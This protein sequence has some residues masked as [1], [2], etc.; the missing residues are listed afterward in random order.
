MVTR[1]TIRRSALV[2]GLIY[3][4]VLAFCASTGALPTGRNMP[5][6]QGWAMCPWILLGWECEPGVM[7][8]P[9]GL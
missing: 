7:R 8:P 5:T 4:P 2:L 3:V 9:S 1:T 6:C